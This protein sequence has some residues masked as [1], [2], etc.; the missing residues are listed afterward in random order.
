MIWEKPGSS[1]NDFSQDRYACMQQSQQPVSG[2]Y[3]NQYGGF[4]SSNIITNNNLFSACMN[5]RGWNL[6]AKTSPQG[7]TPY[8]DAIDAITAEQREACSR[9]DLQA[10]YRKASCFANE[11]TLDQLS[12]PSKISRDE[13]V[14]LTKWR[15]VV[16]EFNKRTAAVHRQYNPNSGNSVAEIIE[17]GTISG[18]ALALELYNGRIPWGEF[19]KRRRE[20][21]IKA[22]DEFKSAVRGN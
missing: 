12:D 17:K 15:T 18:D 8:K 1:Q 21:L 10:F 7:S 22:Q 3:I 5:S 2:A 16:G 20:M 19:N 11:A 6:T 9:D 13:K 4:A 14:A